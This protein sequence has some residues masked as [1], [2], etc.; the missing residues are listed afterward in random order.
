MPAEELFALEIS[1]YRV[2]VRVSWS[3]HFVAGSG[4]RVTP[5]NFGPRESCHGSRTVAKLFGTMTVKALFARFQSMSSDS[6]R[7]AHS[8]TISILP[9]DDCRCSDIGQP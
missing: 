3:V 7:A 1:H 9:I 8:V 5:P 4:P 2:A 6:C